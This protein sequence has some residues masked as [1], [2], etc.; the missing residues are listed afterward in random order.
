MIPQS[1]CEGLVG[2]IFSSIQ[3]EGPMVGRRQVF[4]R[5][6]GC[7]LHCRYCD[8]PGFCG[9]QDACRAE[10][11]PGWGE[12]SELANPLR[13][14]QVVAE[15]D[16]LSGRGLHSVSLTGGEPLCQS[17][18]VGALARECQS[19][20]QKVY[21]ETNGFSMQRFCTLLD[22]LDYA[23]VDLKL[24]SHQACPAEEWEM[25]I[26][27]ERACLDFAFQAGVYAMAKVVILAETPDREVES[28]C[29][30]LEGLD[31]LVL[32]PAW[33]SRIPSRRLLRL[34]EAACTNLSPEKVM[35][36]PQV[37]RLLG[38]L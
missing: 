29:Q 20:G 37:H 15:I 17:D 32:Q 13:P 8:T 33:G 5:M 28:A 24:P 31:A 11:F 9:R 22:H 21:L 7:N 16:R 2:E 4:V 6:A 12:F 38:V 19:G 27:N 1:T 26:Q 10:L 23:A 3:G 25:L 36:I 34:H 35:V 18:F 30:G 14:E